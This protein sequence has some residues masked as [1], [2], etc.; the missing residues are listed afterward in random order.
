MIIVSNPRVSP[1]S[2]TAFEIRTNKP[3]EAKKV[4][5]ALDSYEK[6]KYSSCV[7]KEPYSATYRV[8]RTKK[9][10]ILDVTFNLKERNIL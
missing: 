5:E 8:K 3:K 6:L 7:V 9:V 4:K 10:N 2:N 1:G